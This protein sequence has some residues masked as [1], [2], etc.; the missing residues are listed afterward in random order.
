V[1]LEGGQLLGWGL[2]Q[3]QPAQGLFVG[4]TVCDCHGRLAEK[5]S[6]RGQEPTLLTAL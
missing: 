1:G 4:A 5:D 2:A 6:R 3:S